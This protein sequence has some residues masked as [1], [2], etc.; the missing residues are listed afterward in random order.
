MS[1]LSLLGRGFS[2]EDFLSSEVINDVV[3]PSATSLT[4]CPS[5]TKERTVVVSANTATAFRWTFYG[6]DGVAIPVQIED[7]YEEGTSANDIPTRVAIFRDPFQICQGVHVGKLVYNEDDGLLILPPPAVRNNPSIYQFEAYWLQPAPDGTQLTG[8]G[9]LSVEE[10]VLRAYNFADE[11][12]EYRGPLSLH[13]IRTH[14]RDFP[15]DND[16]IGRAQF[17]DMEIIEAIA[18]PVMV[19]NDTRP[20]TSRYSPANFPHRSQWI[21][22]T[23]AKLHSIEGHWMMRNQMTMQTEGVTVDDR[24]KWNNYIAMAKQ[25]MLEYEAWVRTMKMSENIRRGFRLI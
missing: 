20:P 5:P 3:D 8:S 24:N 6:P 18:Y 9:L 17:S 12:P 13:Q 16:T 7:D 2:E 15:E 14:L 23:I 21:K 25:E 11:A 10:S 19:W 1:L 22:A 4:G